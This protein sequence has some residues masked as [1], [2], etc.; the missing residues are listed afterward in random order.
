MNRCY[1]ALSWRLKNEIIIGNKKL[2]VPVLLITSKLHHGALQ[3]VAAWGSQGERCSVAQYL[4]IW[5]SFVYCEVLP[6]HRRGA[7]VQRN[8]RTWFWISPGVYCPGQVC[9]EIL[10]AAGDQLNSPWFKPS[11]LWAQTSSSRECRELPL[12]SG[13]V[14]GL[15]LTWGLGGG[16][17]G[18]ST[19][20]LVQKWIFFWAWTLQRGVW[21]VNLVLK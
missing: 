21:P 5:R 16:A 4:S 3:S 18:P 7:E 6:F 10:G 12:I 1:P 15:R 19:A 13:L 9:K 14:A 17:G 11:S 8:E 20:T 2:S